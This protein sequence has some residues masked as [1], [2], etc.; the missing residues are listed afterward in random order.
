[1][2]QTLLKIHQTLS[3][4]IILSIVMGICPTFWLV[5]QLLGGLVFKK[6][7]LHILCLRIG[8]NIFGQTKDISTHVFFV[9]YFVQ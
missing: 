2:G 1:M 3:Q 8:Q 9:L 5:P 6:S 7:Q 4:S